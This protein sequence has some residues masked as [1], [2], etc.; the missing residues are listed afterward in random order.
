MEQI[1][2]WILNKS[3]TA[4]YVI[5]AV[6]VIRLFLR[7]LPKLYSYL[8]W[9]V[10]G[11]R[12]ICPVSVS[13]AFSFFNLQFFDS[14]RR[15]QNGW[16][17]APPAGSGTAYEGGMSPAGGTAA[18]ALTMAGETAGGAAGRMEAV[19]QT[20]TEGIAADVWTL[21]PKIAAAVWIIGIAALLI[22]FVCRF[23]KVKRQT[24]AAVLYEGNVFEC[25]NIRSPFVFGI[26]KPRIYIPFH[27]EA[28][29]REYILSHE[30]EHIRRRDYLVKTAAYLTAVIYWFHPLV[31]LSYYLMCQDMEMS[32]D[33][34][35]IGSL[36]NG[37]KQDYSRTLLLFATGNQ[38]PAGPLYFGESNTG[39]RI[40]NVLKYRKPKIAALV[41]GGVLLI[42]FCIFFA[43]DA[44]PENKLTV[45][46]TD[47]APVLSSTISMEESVKHSYELEEN[48]KSYLVYADI[49][50][51]GVYGGRQTI[52]YDS[53]SD[54][55]GNF[56]PMTSID[57]LTGNG[58]NEVKI[59]YNTDRISRTGTFQIP[60][61]IS[62]W[63]G[64]VLWD[65]GKSRSIEADQ[66]Y[67]Y[68][69]RYIGGGDTTNL[70]CFRCENLN[71]AD[72]EEWERCIN[73]N[74]TTVLIYFVFSEK[75]ESELRTE[76]AGTPYDNREETAKGQQAAEGQQA[77]GG[78]TQE[79]GQT[80]TPPLSQVMDR[81]ILKNQDLDQ[82]EDF[83]T[84]WEHLKD[85]DD[86]IPKDRM[87]RLA[88]T[89]DG[90]YTAYGF[91]SPEYGYRGI[92][93]D[94]R[95][96]KEESNFNYFDWDW[97]M[98][99][100]APWLEA[101]DLDHDGRN[102]VVF[103]P[104]AGRGTSYYREY[105]VVFETYNTGR[106]EVCGLDDET[107]QREAENLVEAKVD[108]EAQ[109]VELLGKEN[110]ETIISGM[111]YAGWEEA[112]KAAYQGMDYTGNVRFVT[113]RFGG[114]LYLYLIVTPG[115]VH[116]QSAV[117][118]YDYDQRQLAF[119]V[120][121][122]Q[123]EDG[124]GQFTLSNPSPYEDGVSLENGELYEDGASLESWRP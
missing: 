53:V 7:R 10:V 88:G 11:F 86:D 57:V 116:D 69:A 33:E 106:L 43:T 61:D 123:S 66:P 96:K 120:N 103:C 84:N 42:A 119:T 77:A 107:L 118:E 110:G 47:E 58:Q 5:L 99:F 4:G 30:R 72:E 52:A 76:Y 60:E 2:L 6:L 91:I 56:A 67:I 121:Y 104:C 97:D 89:D 102:E 100:N 105:L 27:M 31:W 39:K 115:V 24:A 62:M 111:S 80:E 68:E 20:G 79:S 70:E 74:C 38:K 112:K 78:Q 16:K 32:C 3:I 114:E 41:L 51:S 63:A 64:D 117:P 40:K 45:S 54:Y 50:E 82:V 95:M 23:L 28:K 26:L 73:Q 12:L 59:M 85:M 15:A 44:K 48:I 90:M 13:G 9:A 49:Y 29:E 124:E 81:I 65:D 22:Y 94:Y 98:Y 1:F 101:G 113:S 92:V 18:D 108:E 109:S 14:A 36:N 46:M 75:S 35:V 93:I 83:E 8:L 71:R 37:G 21:L 34:K 25:D 17:Y 55:N 19:R 87:V 122:S